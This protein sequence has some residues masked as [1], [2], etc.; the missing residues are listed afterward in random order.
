VARIDTKTG[1]DGTT[2]LF[3]GGRVPKSDPRPGAYGAVDE[4]QAA[5]GLTRALGDLGA[6]EA[7]LVVDLESELYVVMAELATAAANQHKLV[8]G[9][10]LVTAEMVTHLEDLIGHYS[11][12]FDMPTEFVIPGGNRAGALFDFA[13]TVVRRAERE[14]VA[15][16]DYQ[17]HAIRYLNRLSDLLWILARWSEGQSLETKTYREERR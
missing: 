5:L 15:I 13:R 2:G 1:D 12:G 16:P 10:T 11:E 4:A 8:A 6:V 17:G 3:Y 9:Q 7:E 14:A